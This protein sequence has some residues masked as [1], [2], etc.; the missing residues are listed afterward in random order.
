M[1]DEVA[2]AAYNKGRNEEEATP[3]QESVAGELL[4]LHCAIALSE[5]EEMAPSFV[6]FVLEP[7]SKPDV[8]RPPQGVLVRTAVD[9]ASPRH[10]EHIP[11]VP[12]HFPQPP[13]A[14]PMSFTFIH[15]H[16]HHGWGRAH[17]SPCMSRLALGEASLH[18]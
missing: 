11:E 10:D 8:D 6:I 1:K 18:H 7:W 3:R 15:G 4:H 17:H 14:I 16:H 9:G 12:N 2:E 5:L 13:M